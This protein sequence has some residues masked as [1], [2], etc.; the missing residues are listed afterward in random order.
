MAN[1]TTRSSNEGS[2]N[3]KTNENI[4]VE[5]M[6]SFPKGNELSFEK[7]ENGVKDF[8]ILELKEGKDCVTIPTFSQK[9]SKNKQ[10]DHIK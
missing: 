8:N 1:S 10:E 4:K 2:G 5:T 9:K 3:V 6:F 7:G